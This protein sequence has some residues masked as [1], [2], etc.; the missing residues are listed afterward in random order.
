MFAA[1][2]RDRLAGMRE[3]ALP[4]TEADRRDAPRL[5]TPPPP[6]ALLALQ[7]GAGNQAVTRMLSRLTY[8]GQQVNYDRPTLTPQE[9][10]AYVDEADRNPEMAYDDYAEKLALKRRAGPP[11][12]PP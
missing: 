9:A 6:H 1:P 10:R 7:Q 12:G 5:R 3:R 2:T 4:G 11:E 8:R